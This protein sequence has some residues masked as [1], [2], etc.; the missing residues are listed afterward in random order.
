MI[1]LPNDAP[2]DIRLLIQVQERTP[3]PKPEGHG[4][5]GSLI[6]R[7]NNSISGVNHISHQRSVLN[8]PLPT[9][10]VKPGILGDS[11][12]KL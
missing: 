7:C 9:E 2:V 5:T 3:F 8:S 12:L 4:L 6:R 11:N 10:R 1:E